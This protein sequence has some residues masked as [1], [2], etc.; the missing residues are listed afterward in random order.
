MIYDRMFRKSLIISSGVVFMVTV[1]FI[2]GVWYFQEKPVPSYT[3]PVVQLTMGTVGD[4]STLV[5]LAHELGYFRENGLD[6]TLMEYSSG[7]PAFQALLN[8]EMDIVLAAD[9]V[10]ALNSF[11]SQDF[12]ILASVA[13][14]KD[15]WELVAR[16]DHGIQTP[17]D[18]KGKKIATIKGTSGEFWLGTFLVFHNLRPEDVTIVDLS[19]EALEAAL[20]KGYIDAVLTFEPHIFNIKKALGVNAIHWSGQNG[21]DNY[22]T[23]YASTT[24]VK[25]Q[26]EVI[27]RF[28]KALVQAETFVKTSKNQTL[29]FIAD[30]FNYDQ[31][32]IAS[33]I[34]KFTFTV[35]LDQSF[36]LILEDAARWIIANKLTDKTEVPNYM[37]FIYMDALE[38]VKPEAITIIR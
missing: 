2:T 3:G 25:N 15:A 28:I 23:I 35:S 11:S 18:L 31:D 5:F 36:L 13:K 7:A 30:H 37:D 17:A 21:Q 8:G 29:G 24:L 38:A 12:K 14:V 6:V 26:P 4:Y 1:F 32:Y 9:F 19:P 22:P 20:L 34:P 33:V 27:E 16:K 10:G